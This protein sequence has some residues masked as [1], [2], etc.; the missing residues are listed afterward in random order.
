MDWHVRG[1]RVLAGWWLTPLL[2]A[3]LVAAGA[4]AGSGLCRGDGD[5]DGCVE[6]KEEEEEE[7]EAGCNVSVMTTM[8]VVVVVVIVVVMVTVLVTSMVMV[9]DDAD[10]TVLCIIVTRWGEAGQIEADRTIVVKTSLTIQISTH[11]RPIRPLD[12]N[13]PTLFYLSLLVSDLRKSSLPRCTFPGTGEGAQ[14]HL[15]Q[16]LNPTQ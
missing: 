1:A 2:D 16:R 3:S 13:V 5:G 11:T 6:E 14:A 7:N 9:D 12:A 10:G 15:R 4:G 8:T